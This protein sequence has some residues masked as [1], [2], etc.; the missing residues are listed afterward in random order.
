MIGELAED[1][2]HFVNKNGV[3]EHQNCEKTAKNETNDLECEHIS[4]V[5]KHHQKRDE[6]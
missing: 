6:D 2:A 5:F 1:G 4:N 3:D